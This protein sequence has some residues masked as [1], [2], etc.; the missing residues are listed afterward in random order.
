MHLSKE[1]F[2]KMKQTDIKNVEPD[3]LVDISKIEIDMK[4]PVSSRV[5]DYIQKVGNPFLVKVGEYIVKIGY[6]DCDGTLNDRM[7]QYIRKVAEIK[8]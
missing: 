6:S 1:Q 7:K 3:T 2:L 5:E 8:Y 4:K